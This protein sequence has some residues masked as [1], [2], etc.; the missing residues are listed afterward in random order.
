MRAITEPDDYGIVDPL[1]EA[2]DARLQAWEDFVALTR[3]WDRLHRYGG[4][5]EDLMH[6][7]CAASMNPDYMPYGPGRFAYHAMQF[8]KEHGWPDTLRA[9]AQAMQDD[10]R[11]RR[12]LVDRR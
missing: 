9:I 2:E 10:E 3:E 11:H 5:L 7:Y 4:V 8:A 12:E 1:K 6:G